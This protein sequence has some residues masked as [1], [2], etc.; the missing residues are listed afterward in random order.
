MDTHE[1]DNIHNV[2][3]ANRYYGL[4]DYGLPHYGQPHTAPPVFQ[5]PGN[6]NRSRRWETSPRNWILEATYIHQLSCH[7]LDPDNEGHTTGI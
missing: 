7:T 1:E 4:P 2:K 5:D 3:P 6:Y